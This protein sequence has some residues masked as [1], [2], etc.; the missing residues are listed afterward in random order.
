[1]PLAEPDPNPVGELPLERPALRPVDADRAELTLH[2][3]P[4]GLVERDETGHAGSVAAH[5]ARGCTGV[6]RV[7]VRSNWHSPRVSFGSSETAV[8]ATDVV[9]RPQAGQPRWQKAKWHRPVSY[10]HLRAHETDSYLVCR[11]L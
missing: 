10:T 6:R 5:G 1:M 3:Y 2:G 4:T 11:L 8:S 9:L 7:R